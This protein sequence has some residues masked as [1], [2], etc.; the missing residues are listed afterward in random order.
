MEQM[1]RYGS[2]AAMYYITQ[3]ISGPSNILRISPG[4]SVQVNRSVPQAAW[5]KCILIEIQ[6][7]AML[8]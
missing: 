5:I 8:E 1:Q 3:H 7:E 4:T 6:M 2:R